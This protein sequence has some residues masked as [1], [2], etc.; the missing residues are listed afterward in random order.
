M[1]LNHTFAIIDN[2]VCPPTAWAEWPKQQKGL[3]SLAATNRVELHDDVIRY[4]SDTLIWIPTFNPST[5]VEQ[6]GLNVWGIT[7]ILR[8]GATTAAEIF[9]NWAALFDFGPDVVTLTG[10]YVLPDATDG[11]GHYEAITVSKPSTVGALRS[12]QQMCHQ[13]ANSD[14]IWL[15]HEGI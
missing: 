11:N 4:I 1:S 13:V 3:L 6:A 14:A 9:G 12:L 15:L 2:Q 7:A 8:S 10:S 5:R